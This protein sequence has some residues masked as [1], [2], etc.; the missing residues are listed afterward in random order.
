[1]TFE[2]QVSYMK[3]HECNKGHRLDFY[4]KLP[5]PYFGYYN[6]DQCSK[7][8]H[9]INKGVWHCCKGCSYDVCL[10]CL[11]FKHKCNSGHALVYE[12]AF[13]SP[14]K[15][16]YNGVYFCDVTGVKAR[17]SN[18][19][20]RCIMGCTYVL[21]PRYVSKVTKADAQKAQHAEQE[22]EDAFNDDEDEEDY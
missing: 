5:H 7:Q 4:G 2:K 20:W 21:T 19:V 22:G 14:L 12:E 18:G 8:N 15:E 11:P 16:V 13:E 17:V 3:K 9:Q 1:M 6:C 10:S